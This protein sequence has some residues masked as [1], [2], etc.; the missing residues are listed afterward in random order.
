MGFQTIT[1]LGWW[2]LHMTLINRVLEGQ[3]ITSNDMG[4]VNQLAV[5]RQITLFGY[6][7]VPIP[8]LN[9]LLG[10][11]GRLINFDYSYFGGQAGFFQYALYSVSFGIMFLL[12]VIIIGGLISNF[13]N[14]VR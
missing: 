4:V 12:F 6:I 14:R 11:V 7:P 1:M 8:N 3:F 13:L 10:G 9:M 5:F 2:F